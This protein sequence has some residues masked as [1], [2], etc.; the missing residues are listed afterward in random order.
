MNMILSAAWKMCDYFKSACV[1]GNELMMSLVRFMEYQPT[2]T[3][4]L[5][6]CKPQ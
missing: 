3:H 6:V 2:L 4:K 5:F 1:A